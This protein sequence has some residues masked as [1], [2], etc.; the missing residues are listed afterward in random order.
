V[1]TSTPVLIFTLQRA[2]PLIMCNLISNS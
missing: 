1:A 2:W